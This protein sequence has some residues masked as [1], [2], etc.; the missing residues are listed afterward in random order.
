MLVAGQRTLRK[1]PAVQRSTFLPPA[2]Q[3][4]RSISGPETLVSTLARIACMTPACTTPAPDDTPL[5]ETREVLLHE[6][7]R[8]ALAVELASLPAVEPHPCEN[9]AVSDEAAIA[10]L[11]SELDPVALDCRDVPAMLKELDDL[12]PERLRHDS[13]AAVL[14]PDGAAKACDPA[15]NKVGGVAASRLTWPVARAL[16]PPW[17]EGPGSPNDE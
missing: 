17:R 14:L 13:H 2:I 10:A 9:G 5:C 8:R 12:N 15:A 16:E 4:S 3:A 1:K 11:L 6:Q 7:D